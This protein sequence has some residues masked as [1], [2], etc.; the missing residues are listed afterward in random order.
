MQQFRQIV[1]EIVTDKFPTYKDTIGVYNN[2]ASFRLPFV[3]KEEAT[4]FAANFA[5]LAIS[6][7]MQSF[8]IDVRYFDEILHDSQHMRFVYGVAHRAPE[9]VDGG[10]RDG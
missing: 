8:I 1:D 4:V 3:C 2:R 7:G 5:H 10:Q 6:K 9:I